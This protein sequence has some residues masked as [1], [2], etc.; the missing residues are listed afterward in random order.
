M[1]A[2]F[3]CVITPLFWAT[4]HTTIST[5]AFMKKKEIADT[6]VRRVG[7]TNKRFEI[8]FSEYFTFV[9]SKE[10]KLV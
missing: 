4:S 9:E 10:D 8:R 7:K 5:L 1:R 2:E 3:S 6:F